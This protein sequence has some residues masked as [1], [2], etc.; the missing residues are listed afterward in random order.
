MAERINENGVDVWRIH[1]GDSEALFVPSLG[2]TGSSIRLRG[3]E[4]LFSHDFFRSC[5]PDETRE[6]WPFLFP[7]CGRLKHD[8]VRGQYV[9]KGQTYQLPLHGFSLNRTWTVLGDADENV[10]RMQLLADPETLENYPF[11]FRVELTYRFEDEALICDFLIANE[12]D[13]PMPYYAGFHPYLLVEHKERTQ[14]SWG[15]EKA[16]CYTKDFMSIECEKP[17]PE[18]PVRLDDPALQDLLTGVGDDHAMTMR[19]PDG[20]VLH[21]DLE[22]LSRSDMFPYVQ[23]YGPPG[24]P[25][26]CYEPWMGR[27]NIL[28]SGE[29]LYELPPG[30]EDRGRLRMWLE[31]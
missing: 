26:F 6:G 22:N 27:P 13:E 9:W 19:Y 4:L 31:S 5:G 7:I 12:G 29:G 8:G 25:Y 11:E 15:A 20:A 2:G 3:R 18:M 21:M 24:E 16:F 23:F 14:L 10:L 28:N 30:G 1:Q 17:I